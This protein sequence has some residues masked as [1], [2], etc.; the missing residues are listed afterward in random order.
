MYEAAG[1]GKGVLDGVVE[2]AGNGGLVEAGHQLVDL[3]SKLQHHR[4]GC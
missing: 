2:Q 1:G 3:H 4:P